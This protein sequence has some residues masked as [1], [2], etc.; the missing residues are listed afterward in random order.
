MSTGGAI[1]LG[2]LLKAV[3][4]SYPT[5][6]SVDRNFVIKGCMIDARRIDFL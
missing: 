1:T 6:S 5:I 2:S 4:V 3:E